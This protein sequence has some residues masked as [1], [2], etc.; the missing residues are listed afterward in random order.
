RVLPGRFVEHTVDVHGGCLDTGYP[1]LGLRE[2]AVVHGM[3]IAR[4]LKEEEKDG[5]HEGLKYIAE[6]ELRNAECQNDSD[7]SSVTLLEPT[8]SIPQFIRIA[9]PRSD[10]ATPPAA[11]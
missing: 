8:R 10:P 9:A 5:E 2:E 1:H 4:G 7:D 3:R 11:P 6:C